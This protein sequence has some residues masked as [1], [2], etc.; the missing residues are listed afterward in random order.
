MDSGGRG[1]LFSNNF[2]GGRLQHVGSGSGP[3]LVASSAGGFPQNG[4]LQQQQSQAA[5][6]QLNADRD[7]FG[8]G[9]GSL[10]GGPGIG[11]EVGDLSMLGDGGGMSGMGGLGMDMGLPMDLD[12]DLSSAG[13][14]GYGGG[15]MPAGLQ[16]SGMNTSV[17]SEQLMGGSLGHGGSGNTGYG[18]P[19]PQSGSTLTEFTKRRNWSQRI[20]E[21][22]KDFLHILTP[23][24]RILYVS[25][26]CRAITGY[27][28]NALVGKFIG[29][30]VHPDDSGI[31][32]RE[33][34]ESIASGNS[35]RFF[36][37][38]KKD[39]GTYM[40]LECDGHPHISVE[41]P[42]EPQGYNASHQNGSQA[43]GMCRGFF[44]M[45]RP[46]PTKNAALL[47][48]F[49]EHKMENERLM[50]RIEELR[51]EELEEVEENP[52]QAISISP[53][54]S[55]PRAGNGV[56]SESPAVAI[57]YQG[58]PPPAKPP[59]L[60]TALTRQNLDNVLSAQKQDSMADKMSRYEANS[61]H[62]ESIELMTGLRYRD[63][64]RSHGISTGDASPALI[65]GD[66]GIA[67]LADRDREAGKKERKKL[68]VADE[69]VCAICGT[70]D[71]PEWRKGPRG[72]KT[73]CNAC[74]LRWAKKEKKRG[75]PEEGKGESSPVGMLAMGQ[76]EGAMLPGV[77]L[78]TQTMTGGS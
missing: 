20:I 42:T 35:L 41:R 59:A 22:L 50:K 54:E 65:R 1:G 38:F 58:M 45:A 73:L 68:K 29:E 4:Y 76:L 30:Y 44:M 49:L 15:G 34:N 13:T 64:E 24:G 7:A 11:I 46:Y 28:S 36:Y 72:P 62:L 12:M 2:H 60:N 10:V 33:F 3:G 37:R 39:D 78:P 17:P 9:G 23:D 77:G 27:E 8:L 5:H 74:G 40:I 66:A 43:G 14:D 51:R 25:P 47:D 53:S 61:T 6:Y 16:Q 19:A 71:S 48:S 56:S 31:F 69:Y 67:I 32:M 52:D 18:L 55:S 70:L 21:E 57:N 63:G 26:S 75:G